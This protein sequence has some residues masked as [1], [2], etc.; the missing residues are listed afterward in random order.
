MK[1]SQSCEIR[2]EKENIIED[3]IGPIEE[4]KQ[5]SNRMY[6]AMKSLQNMR[7]KVPL[8]VD[9]ENGITD[10]ETQI[11]IITS[12]FTN[13]FCSKDSEEIDR[14]KLRKQSNA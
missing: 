11:K 7:N 10:T 3:A 9:A 4:I 1:C 2:K 6:V 13:M 14:I 5:D 8:V 12:F